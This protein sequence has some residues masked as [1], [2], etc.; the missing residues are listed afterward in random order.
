MVTGLWTCW[1]RKPVAVG[2]WTPEGPIEQLG[3]FA[4]EP[5]H[6]TMSP[7]DRLTICTPHHGSASVSDS[8][9]VACAA[10]N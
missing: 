2:R 6:A 7:D 10:G 9:A 5:V 8:A 1:V 3:D 4:L